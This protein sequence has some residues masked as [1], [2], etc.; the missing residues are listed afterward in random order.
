MSCMKQKLHVCM[1]R[2]LT[3]PGSVSVVAAP[4]RAQ[5]V[6]AGQYN[7]RIP[8]A[9]LEDIALYVL[10]SLS[11]NAFRTRAGNMYVSFMPELVGRRFSEVAFFFQV[12]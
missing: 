8:A 9:L 4:S 10:L 12:L 7:C 1:F 11:L 3:G 2:I 6:H 5:I